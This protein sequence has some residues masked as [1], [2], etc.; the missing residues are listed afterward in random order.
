MQIETPTAYSFNLLTCQ[1]PHCTA[2]HLISYDKNEFPIM[3]TPIS[4]QHLPEVIEKM[5]DY[6]YALSALANGE[7]SKA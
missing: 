5:R 6:L 1:H 2:L 4:A 3:D 7:D